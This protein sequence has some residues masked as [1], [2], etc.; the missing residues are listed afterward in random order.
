[1][2]KSI[3]KMNVEWYTEQD[4]KFEKGLD[5]H[6]KSYENFWDYLDGCGDFG[7]SLWNV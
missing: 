4:V 6:G 2:L 5:A 3:A 7:N 1:M